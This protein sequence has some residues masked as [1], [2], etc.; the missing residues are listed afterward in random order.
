MRARP[1]RWISA[2]LRLLPVAL[3]LPLVAG[4]CV[5]SYLL[6]EQEASAEEVG[7]LCLAAALLAICLWSVS[8]ARSLR[9]AVRS[10]RH[11][12]DWEQ[13]G[14]RANLRGARKSVW[15]VDAPAPLLVLSG[16][17]RPRLV[18]S[19]SV[20]ATLTT[21]QLRAALRHEEA[22]RDSRDNLKRLLLL[23]S[24]GLLPGWHGFH[25]LERGWSRMAEWAA[26]DAAVAGDQR[27]S[28]ALAAA[29]V[30][31]AR[32]GGTQASTPLFATFLAD[33]VD[34]L[35]RVDRLLRPAMA[36]A[37]PRRM[38]VIVATAALSVAYVAA[39]L[40]PATLES[41]HRLLE[42]LMR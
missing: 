26:D 15:I 3:A 32:M 29:L 25:A 18:I 33:G 39:S 13:V 42:N 5:P 2:G 27:L 36:T 1:R 4:L 7:S 30:R 38:P 22:H 14:S 19:R 40:R 37:A 16:V 6:L 41:A 11:A 17:F 24:P 21:E 28:L 34:L 35:T 31:I 20:A 10:M 9:A 12:R 8:I 23:L